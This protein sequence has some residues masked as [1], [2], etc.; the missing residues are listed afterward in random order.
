MGLTSSRLGCTGRA[1][2]DKAAISHSDCKKNKA[3]KSSFDD[4]LK[5]VRLFLRKADSET[6]KNNVGNYYT[7]SSR[8][9]R[10]EF[11]HGDKSIRTSLRLVGETDFKLRRLIGTGGFGAVFRGTRTATGRSYALK[12][13]PMEAMA[14]SA[15][16]G[17]KTSTDETILY[18]ERTVLARCREHPFIVSLEYAFHTNCYAV[19]ALEYV[20]GGTLSRLIACSP[21]RML[22]F[23]LAKTYAMELTLALNFM[24][25]NGIIYRDLKPSNVLITRDGH[26]KLTDFGLAGSMVRKKVD[27][28]QSA[29]KVDDLSKLPL[30]PALLRGATN[31]RCEEVTGSTG[32][33]TDSSDGPEVSNQEERSICSAKERDL[34]WV[35]RRTVCGTAGY[36]PPEQVQE[37]FVDYASR[38]G[39]DERADWFALGVCCYSMMTGNR[40]FPTKRELLKSEHSQ[41]SLYSDDGELPQIGNL[42]DSA[43]RKVL[44][45]VEFRCLMFQVRYPPQLFRPEPNA[46]S[47]LEA[48]LSR[49]PKERPR[50]NDI[51]SHPWMKNEEFEEAAVLRRPI[52]QWVRDHAYLQAIEVMNKRGN[53]QMRRLSFLSGR[54]D[55]GSLDDFVEDL[56]RGIEDEKR[57]RS[58]AARWKTRPNRGTLRL[59]RHWNFIS[60]D[61]IRLEIEASNSDH[62]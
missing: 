2:K 45:D 39:Y 52:P 61:A 56:F 16:S 46:Q 29:N 49:D 6:I 27:K 35:R 21:G 8:P 40:P 1:K 31:F 7:L 17:G 55:Q 5:D 9:K 47:F 32:D 14:R 48:L 44:N 59:F 18:M 24:H 62:C 41:R 4:A 34:R 33:V 10:L 54:K 42:D 25:K 22:P 23:D 12:V 51:V 50:Y 53:P 19:L 60:D 30:S 36:R 11:A 37:R 28:E 20:E 13:Q 58:S 3:R 15:R 26:L 57:R 38:S 43:T